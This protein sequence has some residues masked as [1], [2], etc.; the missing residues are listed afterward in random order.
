MSHRRAAPGCSAFVLACCSLAACGTGAPARTHAVTPS[1]ISATDYRLEMPACHLVMDVNPQIGARVSALGIGSADVI[2]PY[3][4]DG[5][6]YDGTAACNNSGSTFWTSPQR[7]WPSGAWPPIASVDGNPYTPNVSG[8][9]LIMT[10]SE[11]AA[12]GASVEKDF[13]ADDKSCSIALRYIIRAAR[14]FAA[15]PW[16]IT[17]VPRGGIAFFP[18]GEGT[19]LA[20]GPLSPYTTITTATS[21]NTVWVDDSTRAAPV[22]AGGSKLIADGADGWLA[23]AVGDVL[24]IKKFTDVPPASFAPGEGNIEIY[25]GSDYLELE[26]QGA[27]THLAGGESMP[28]M[29]QWRAVAIPNTVAVVAG[30]ASLLAFARQQGVN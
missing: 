20:A 21:P 24:F 10:G 30:S 13:S 12:S 23:Y 25:P 2:K 14:P 8:E 5:G 22:P 16:E 6:A 1:R 19:R 4:C 15:A 11:N 3:G 26:V 18:E 28:W 7:A 27:Y 9:H 17:R 29:V